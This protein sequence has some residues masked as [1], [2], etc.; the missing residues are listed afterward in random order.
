MIY[1]LGGLINYL[2]LFSTLI[3]EESRDTSEALT[4]D[5][6]K[7]INFGFKNF[8]ADFPSYFTTEINTVLMTLSGEIHVAAYSMVYPIYITVY[9]ISVGFTV[10]VRTELNHLLGQSKLNSAKL[11][12]SKFEKIFFLLAFLIFVISMIVTKICLK[13][14]IFGKEIGPIVDDSIWFFSALNGLGAPLILARTMFKTLEKQ[15]VINRLNFYQYFLIQSGYILCVYLVLGMKGMWIN[16]SLVYY[17]PM[18]FI[19]FGLLREY[20]WRGKVGR[21]R[22][23]K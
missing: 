15:D 8:L 12:F 13:F 4:K 19:F 23:R 7:I 20:G 10:Q 1:E 6:R 3:P 5:Y 2:Q 17:C 21:K 11:L 18:L 9:M 16:A 22:L 14:E